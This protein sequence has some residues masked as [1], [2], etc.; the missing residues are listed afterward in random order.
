L[1]APGLNSLAGGGGVAYTLAVRNKLTEELAVCGLNAALAVAECHPESVNRLFLR[2]ERLPLFSG[3]CKHL[4]VRRRPYKFCDDEELERLCRSAH[5][6]GV[7]AMIF[8]PEVE[9]AGEADLAAW[10]EA[11]RPV[12]VLHDVGNDLNLGAIIRSAAFFEAGAVVISGCERMTTAA[13]RAAEGGMEHVTLRS[14]RDTAAFLRAASDAGNFVVGTDTRARLRLSALPGLREGR[15]GAAVLAL[16]NEETGLPE[17]VLGA[18]ERVVRIPGSGLVESLNVA[19]AAAVFL[20]A[21][22][23]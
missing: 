23:E 13:Y 7:V 21:L 22:Y 18:C 6:Q 9:A 4:A 5:H 17:R 19:Q 12:L 16:G 3:L 11:R 20:Y 15:G 1:G 8:A 14:V 2:E 10:T